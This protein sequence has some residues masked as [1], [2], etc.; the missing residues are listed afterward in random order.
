MGRKPVSWISLDVRAAVREVCKPEQ[1]G[2]QNGGLGMCYRYVLIGA[3]CP[4]SEVGREKGS[5]SFL[6]TESLVS[7]KC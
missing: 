1:P 5:G 7:E 4:M 6:P 3:R 2:I